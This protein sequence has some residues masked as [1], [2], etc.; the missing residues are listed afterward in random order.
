MLL[1]SPE[2]FVKHKLLGSPPGVSNLL[3][4]GQGL[5]VCFLMVSQVTLLLLAQSNA[6]ITTALQNPKAAHLLFRRLKD[7]EAL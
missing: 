5:K 1:E 6:L 3:G 4:L 2:V 7:R